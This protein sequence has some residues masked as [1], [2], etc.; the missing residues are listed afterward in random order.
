MPEE[1]RIA[2]TSATP[3]GTTG[4][5]LSKVGVGSSRGGGG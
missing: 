1:F 4:S 2:S 3:A 5:S